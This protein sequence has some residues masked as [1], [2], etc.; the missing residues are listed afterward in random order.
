MLKIRTFHILI[1]QGVVGS[2]PWQVGVEYS[3]FSGLLAMMLGRC[4]GEAAICGRLGAHVALSF[5]F[6]QNMWKFVSSCLC[7]ARP[8]FVYVSEYTCICAVVLC[9]AW[10]GAASGCLLERDILSRVL[11]Q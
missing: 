10:E 8:P 7:Q 5:A 6:Y 3:R 4:H 9:L 11:R 1:L 2:S